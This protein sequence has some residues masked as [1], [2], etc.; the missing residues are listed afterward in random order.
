MRVQA[1]MVSFGMPLGD[2]LIQSLRHTLLPPA[3]VPILTLLLLGKGAAESDTLVKRHP[4]IAGEWITIAGNPDLG[5]WTSDEQEPVDFGIWQA[6]DGDWQLWSCIRKTKHPGRTRIF[7]RWE[8]TH[9]TMP[10]W[11]PRGI[12]FTG[13]GTVGETVGGMQAPYVIRVEEEW[14]MFY[15]DYRHICLATSVDGKTFTKALERGMTGLFGEGPMAHARDPMLIQI[16]PRWYCYYSAHP[17]GA[18]GIWLRT[19]TD[20]TQWSESQCV[21]T[22][23]QAGD[24]WWNFECPH[25]VRHLGWFYLFHTQNYAAGKQQ[26]SVYCSADPTWFGVDDDSNF[27]GHLPIAAPELIY[28]DHQWYIA[29]LTSD[30][31]GIRIAPLAWK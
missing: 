3:A 16:G 28:H 27:L 4:T 11:E 10:N 24:A 9:L 31:D 14:K 25:V 5:E 17:R 22:G 2:P 29:A 20:F 30:L 23:G 15:G 13:D 26:T 18:H 1:A 21:M 8:S 19:T 12:T 7:H 6:A